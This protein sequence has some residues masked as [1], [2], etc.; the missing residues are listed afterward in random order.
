[1]LFLTDHREEKKEREKKLR[2]HHWLLAGR[3]DLFGVISNEPGQGR[4]LFQP[5]KDFG[6]A[7]ASMTVLRKLHCGEI[8]EILW[9]ENLED[10]TVL[11]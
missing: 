10:K 3:C 1:M 11:H 9:I 7:Y 8:C 4:T 6:D 5:L 2:S